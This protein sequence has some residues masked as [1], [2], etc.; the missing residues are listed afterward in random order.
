[1][2]TDPILPEKHCDSSGV[3]E[4]LQQILHS[5]EFRGALQLQSLLKF[6]VENSICGHD[7]ALKERIIGMSVFGR[8]PDYETGDD[9][10]VRSRARQLRTRLER[11]YD[12]EEAKDS[13]I[14][15]VIPKGSYRPAFFPRGR[16][17]ASKSGMKPLVNDQLHVEV[18]GKIASEENSHVEPVFSAPQS[19]GPAQWHAW[20]TVFLLACAL[21][22][23]FAAFIGIVKWPR[24]NLDLLW[25]PV[26]DS[27]KKVIIY[28]G[29]LQVYMPSSIYN[30]STLSVQ[31][32]DMD[33]PFVPGIGSAPGPAP[34]EPAEPAK[35]MVV[36]PYRY[37][38]SETIETN[39][40]VAALLNA[41]HLS[42]ESRAE[43]NLPFVDLH[44]SP[45]VLV[46]AYSNNWTMVLMQDLPFFFDRGGRVHERGA[47]G[48]VWSTPPAKDDRI[49][50]DY[51]IV[52]RLLDS[53]ARGPVI[54]VA[55]ITTCGT[56][57]AT[58][59]VTDPMQQRML[60]S[61]PR[62]ALERKNLEFVLRA[63]LINCNPTSLD[64][65]AQRFW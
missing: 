43:P 50:Q 23:A 34:K 63:S 10:I 14:Q 41:H 28:N 12:S 16:S 37:V 24:S 44:G 9:P 64:I 8:K 21:V 36:A 47:Q 25:S 4:S 48:R 22:L 38:R 52:V 59:F 53:K 42:V 19:T 27:K 57:A 60:D 11:Y 33:Q 5:K 7:D 30:Y 32:G 20:R 26:F 6:I 39:L 13:A 40:R 1:M 18:P 61:F 45:I 56:E 17:S 31:P 2:A 15:I 58:E 54:I 3:D 35:D 29:S 46:G 55:G 62:Y 65:V 49:A 51:A